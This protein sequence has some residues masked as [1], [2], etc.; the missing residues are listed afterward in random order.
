MTKSENVSARVIGKEATCFR[1]HFRC[2]MQMFRHGNG[3]TT[4]T[5]SKYV[6][7]E[8]DRW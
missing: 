2:Q 7:H 4:R 6:P 1:D 8:P 3:P 5:S